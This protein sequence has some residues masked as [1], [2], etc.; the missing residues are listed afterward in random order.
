[1]HNLETRKKSVKVLIYCTICLSLNVGL[2]KISNIL[3][4]PFT[5]DSIGTIFGASILP[6]YYVL[7]ISGLTSLIASAIINPFFI[8][9]IGTQIVIAITSVILVKLSF[10]KSLHKSIF[11]GLIIG[12]VSAIVS[13]PVTALVFGGVSVPSITAINILLLTSGKNLWESVICGSLIVESIDKVVAGI[14]VYLS[15]KRL[16]IKL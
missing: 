10:F 9:Y 4:L 8:Y 12:I 16:N 3:G 5:M 14:F 13:A 1:M 2:G 6:W 7:L 15:L 11:A